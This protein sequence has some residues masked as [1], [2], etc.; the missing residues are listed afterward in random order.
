[1]LT[2]TGFYWALAWVIWAIPTLLTASLEV[3]I[4]ALIPAGLILLLLLRTE[5]EREQR[6][7][8][9]G[10]SQRYTCWQPHVQQAMGQQSQQRTRGRTLY[11]D[12]QDTLRET[13]CNPLY[14]CGQ[15]GLE[16]WWLYDWDG[17]Y[18]EESPYDV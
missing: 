14:G 10:A 1:M 2:R 9:Q 15:A 3:G 5:R 8:A 12:V 18:P 11:D 7:E 6:I 4:L 16:N 13:P 17:D